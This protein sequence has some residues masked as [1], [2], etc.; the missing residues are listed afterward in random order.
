MRR[1]T[2]AFRWLPILLTLAAAPCLLPAT[3]GA[4]AVATPALMNFQ[5]RIARP[6]GTPVA[7]GN[8]SIRFSLY[9][10]LTGGTKLWEQTVNPVTVRNGTF[11]AQLNVGANFQNGAT[12]ATLFNGNLWLEI[13]IGADAALTPRQQLVSVAYAQKAGTV[14]DGSITGAKI[15]DGTITAAKLAAGAGGT[16]SGAAGGDLTGTY[17]NPGLRTQ[18]SSLF[19]VSGTLMSAL[20]GGAGSMN[21][22]QNTVTAQNQDEAWQSFTPSSNGNLTAIE[23]YIGTTTGVNKTIPLTIYAGEGTTGGVLRQVSITVTPTMGFQNFTISPP[24]ALTSG[25]KYTFY[26]GRSSSLQFGYADNNPYAGGIADLNGGLDYAFRT[27]M[28]TTANGRVEV[29]GDLTS[30]GFVG[31]A[32]NKVLEFGFGVGGKEGNAGKIGYQTFTADA[33]DIVGAGT[34]NTNRKIKFHAEGGATFAGKVGIG[35]TPGF[36]LSF[37]NTL[38]DKISLWGQSGNHYGFGIQGG[39]LQIHTANAADSVAFGHGSSGSFTETMRVKGDGNVGI[40]TNNPTAKLDVNG[41]VNI[42]GGI[43]SGAITSSGAITANTLTAGAVIAGTVITGPIASGA[44]TAGGAVVHGN[45]VSLGNFAGDGAIGSA[46]ATVDATSTILINQTTTF[47][48]LTIPNPT[49]ATAGRMVRI[50][51]TGTA[52]FQVQGAAHIPPGRAI[53]FLWTGSAWL[54]DTN[55]KRVLTGTVNIGDIGG[56]SGGSRTVTGDFASASNNTL[57]GANTQTT[58]NLG[59]SLPASYLV[60]ISVGTTDSSDSGYENSN[61]THPPTVGNRT[62]TSFQIRWEETSGSTQTILAHI[63][64][65][66]Q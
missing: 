7:N 49:G 22:A 60:V 30:S 59:W 25:Q 44:I 24:V 4:Q 28:N 10:A 12:A 61:D 46:A 27:Y 51:N 47:R 65:I 53:T 29:N 9:N 18:A 54:P 15:A 62:T 6:D 36:P 38:G 3:A 57:N 55:S 63:T 2:S 39:L 16:P 58:V 32:S 8:Y 21:V 41:N 56:S 66:E 20:Q 17:P 48:S 35:T 42:A 50:V 64:V 1:T 34:T 52:K 13:K 23:V 40:G 33:L 26:I 19:K 14:P 5:G 37:P 43:A 11:A 45:A 31:I